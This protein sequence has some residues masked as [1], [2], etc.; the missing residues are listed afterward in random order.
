M[1]LLG[2]VNTPCH[3]KN[4]VSWLCEQEVVALNMA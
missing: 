4:G 2:N 3:T 1:T